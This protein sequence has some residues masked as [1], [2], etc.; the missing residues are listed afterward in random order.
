MQPIVS[1]NGSDFAVISSSISHQDPSAILATFPFKWQ[2][3]DA[4]K[5]KLHKVKGV[6]LSKWASSALT[7]SI[8]KSNIRVNS[9]A[10]D[11]LT[12]AE[13]AGLTELD[14]SLLGRN[15]M[16]ASNATYVVSLNVT[17]GQQAQQTVRVFNSLCIT[18]I[19]QHAARKN[20]Q[21]D[22]GPEADWIDCLSSAG[23]NLVGCDETIVP[24]RPAE[25]WSY[26][27]EREEWIRSFGP[28]A[29]R[30]YYTALKSS[31]SSQSF[32]R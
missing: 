25:A 11:L 29:S 18:P 23:D 12:L 3:C 19:L 7:C 24:T 28:G 2:P 1:R 16:A 30:E 10:N 6:K 31:P 14:V 27:A 22:L 13:V 9:P 8:P 32:T 4:L 5:P 26:D 17:R 15:D 20:L 21:Y